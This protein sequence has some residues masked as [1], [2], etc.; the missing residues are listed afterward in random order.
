VGCRSSDTHTG[1]QLSTAGAGHAANAGQT[2][3]AGQ[4][5]AHAD[6]GRGAESSAAADGGV[7]GQGASGTG[8]DGGATNHAGV[9]VA[10]DGGG[11]DLSS[12]LFDADQLPRFDI[13]L[14]SAARSALATNPGSYVRATLRYQD[15]TVE[16]VGLRIKGEASLRTLEQKAAF[17]LKFDEFVPNQA[18]RGL[19]RVTLNNMVSDASFIAERLAYHMF[20]AAGLPAPRCNHALVYVD[21]EYYGV[22]A[23][24]ESEDKTFLKRWF[25]SDQGNLYEDGQVDLDPGNETSFDLETNETANDRSDLRAFI[26]G[27]AAAGGETFMDDLAPELDTDHYLHFAAL[28]AVVNQW[29][30]YSYT[31]FEPNNFRLYHDPSRGKFVFLPW[32]MDLSMKPFPYTS[33]TQIPVLAVPRYE[34]NAGARDAGGLLWRR[35]LQSA[36]CKARFAQVMRDVVTRYESE[37][38]EALAER[39]YTQIKDHVY[40]DTRKELT[41]Q[42][43]ETAYQSVRSIIRNRASSIRAEL[44]AAGL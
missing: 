27:I 20:I 30:G 32:G 4:A 10:T 28:E 6:A 12:E 24:V 22:Y 8:S 3:E 15:Q 17:K 43:F 13:A 31:Y 1:H 39:Y 29:D 37:N 16:N 23:N 40:E 25:A 7:A 19:R 38:L 41:N 14:T 26:D 9:G 33:R 21:D 2:A 5:S 44:T 34:D 42:E 35:C 18:F 11:I 36:S